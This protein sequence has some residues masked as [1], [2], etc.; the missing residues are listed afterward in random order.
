[1]DKK[2]WIVAS[3][4]LLVLV[5]G[6]FA[7]TGGGISEETFKEIQLEAYQAGAQYGFDEAVT[8]LAEM[9][10]TCE[11]VPLRIE[12]ETFNVIAVG[13]LQQAEE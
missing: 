6:Y 7:V 9:A 13:C 12:N 8:R 3:L 10:I 11:Q 1:M 5:L 2:M 4:S